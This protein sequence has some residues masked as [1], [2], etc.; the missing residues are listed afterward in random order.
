MLIYMY[1]VGPFNGFNKLVDLSG[2]N[3]ISVSNH[4]FYW[5]NCITDTNNCALLL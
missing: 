1:D 5:M 3:I 4:I 2:C